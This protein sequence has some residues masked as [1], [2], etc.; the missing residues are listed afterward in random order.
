MGLGLRP[1]HYHDWKNVSKELWVEVMTDNYIH[2]AGGRGRFHLSETVKNRRT[3]MHGVGMNIAGTSPLDARYLDGLSELAE[4]VQ[5]RVISDH[6][7]F[8]RT[9]SKATYDLLPIPYTK[10]NL[11]WV[12]HRVKEAQRVV[13]RRLSFE[14][15]SR[16]VRFKTDEMSET[17][18]LAR[19]CLETGCGILLDVNNVLVTSHNL[20]SSPEDELKHL[21]PWMVTQYH[22]AGHT[23]HGSWLHDTHDQPVAENCW[24]LLSNCLQRLGLH[25][26]VLENDDSNS[27]FTTL[28]N[29]LETGIQKIGFIESEQKVPHGLAE[30]QNRF[31]DAV[32]TAP[33]EDVAT[34]DLSIVDSLGHQVDVY[35]NCFYTRITQTL[36]E[37]LLTPLNDKFGS[38]RVQAWIANYAIDSGLKGVLL[39]D[40]LLGLAGYLKSKNLDEDYPEL[41]QHL[42]LCIARWNILTSADKEFSTPTA[43]TPLGEIHLNPTAIIVP[44]SQRT[45]PSADISS[46][47]SNTFAHAGHILF[48]SSKCDLHTVTIPEECNDI[49]SQLGDGASLETALDANG[50]HHEDSSSQ[51]VQTWLTTL[52]RLGGLTTKVVAVL[53]ATFFISDEASAEVWKGQTRRLLQVSASVLDDIPAGLAEPSIGQLSIDLGTSATLV[54]NIDSRVGS[55]TEG[56]PAAPVHVLPTLGV[57]LAPMSPQLLKFSILIRGF[58]GWLP[59]QASKRILAGNSTFTQTKYGLEVQASDTNAVLSDEI[60]WGTGLYLQTGD[61]QLNGRFSSSAQTESTDSF[62]T[63]NASAGLSISAIHRKTGIHS[64]VIAFKRNAT[65]EFFIA[66][67]KN[68]LLVKDDNGDLTKNAGEGNF[69]GQ[70]SL[71][72]QASPRLQIGAAQL[73]IPARLSAIRFFIRVQTPILKAEV[74][75]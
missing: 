58:V 8:T 11:R 24:E 27:T 37:T 62:K 68:L 29:E 44:A 59:G 56:V 46:R 54:P 39:Q 66:E 2:Q 15:L 67:D 14:N 1:G 16:Y 7:C 51:T 47:V 22:V 65:S 4:M 71:G 18:F 64:E 45:E 40:N 36:S 50:R 21:E 35:R 72:W 43:E 74:E 3:V 30:L 69:G 61:S 19:L 49:A 70:V 26:I 42:E 12:A 33:W 48:R 5:P 23:N 75:R 63:S 10:E 52:F 60:L 41:N 28:I 17:E 57:S 55:K 31:V 9:D 13:G 25:P 53:L 6:L 38:H 34:R 73:F 32:Y 20:K